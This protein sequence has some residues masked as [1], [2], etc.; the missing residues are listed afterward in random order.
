MSWSSNDYYR[1]LLIYILSL[2][3][4]PIISTASYKYRPNY[5]F[6]KSVKIIN[7][8]NKPLPYLIVKLI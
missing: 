8:K 1:Y 5:A 6:W 4:H 2:T 7:S 3:L